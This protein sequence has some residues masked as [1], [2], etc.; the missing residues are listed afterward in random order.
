[1]LDIILDTLL[2]S[3]K[4]IPFLFL[5]YL[6]M[7]Y[8]EHKTGA[9]TQN[10]VKKAGKWGPL[11]GGMVGVLPQCGFSVAASNL[12][13]GRVITLGTLFAI[14]LSTSD[15]MLPIFI[16]ERAPLKMILGILLIKMVIGIVV[17]FVIDFVFR[18][19]HEEH[20][21]IHDLCEH[22]HCHCEQGILR[23]AIN[24]T[25]QITLFIILISFALN[26]ALY[27]VGE[28][29]LAGFLMDNPFLGPILSGI[30]GL[31]PNCAASVVITQLFLQNVIGVGSML[32]GLL[33]G[34]GVGLLI[35]FR[36]NHDKKENVKILGLLYLIGVLIGIVVELV[37]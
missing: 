11:L 36:V 18:K 6:A 29:T 13:A 5:T 10:M 35:L 28:D 37:M 23:S 9:K 2:D 15:E 25:V 19:G 7:E 31:I 21:H 33:V 1:M 30:V 16:S 32:A 8:L 34:T 24:H 27:F 4:L 26:L 17:G 3:V 22:D 14:Y 20:E 12:Y